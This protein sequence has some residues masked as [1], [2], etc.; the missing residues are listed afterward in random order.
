MKL[1]LFKLHE[2]RKTEIFFSRDEF[3][4]KKIPYILLKNIQKLSDFIDR[5]HL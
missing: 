4:I 5:C 2:S 3:N 1:V